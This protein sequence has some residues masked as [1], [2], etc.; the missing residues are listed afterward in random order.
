ML[1]HAREAF[2]TF[3][4][5]GLLAFPVAL[6]LLFGVIVWRARQDD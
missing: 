5:V 2:V 6:L 1:D 4:G 3:G